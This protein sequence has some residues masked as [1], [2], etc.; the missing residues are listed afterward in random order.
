M[1][2]PEIFKRENMD[3]K[4]HSAKA[5]LGARRSEGVW[6][7]LM[8]LKT[9]NPLSSFA[10]VPENWRFENQ[11]Q[12]EK[13]ILLLRQH[14]I[15]NLPW[16]LLVGVLILVPSFWDFLPWAGM[17][18]GRFVLMTVILWYLMVTAFALE[19]F[20]DWYYNVY[21]V[22]DERVIDIDFYGLLYKDLSVVKLDTIQ[23]INY[24]QTG[25]IAAIF[26]YGDV[27]IQTAAERR[28]LDF[29]K[30]PNPNKVVDILYK[31]IDEE[32]QEKLEGR[33]K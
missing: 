4:P 21:I 14:P 30:V 13:I 24:K 11:E 20:L 27:F 12:D 32:E 10:I 15:V 33:T 6:Q 25:G 2:M 23:Q 8:H 31:L 28:Q 7:S 1:F 3:E 22:T 29:M 19:K 26:N 18:P 9:N 17:M 16:L 5:S